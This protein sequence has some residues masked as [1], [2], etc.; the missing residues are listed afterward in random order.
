MTE[1]TDAEI[2]ATE[3]A[4]HALRRSAGSD[5][6]AIL[7]LLYSQLEAGRLA[8]RREETTSEQEG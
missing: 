8:S 1:Q 7:P 5:V 6:H 2:E 4:E 3:L